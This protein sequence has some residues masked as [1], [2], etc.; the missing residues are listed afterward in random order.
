MRLFRAGHSFGEYIVCAG[1]SRCYVLLFSSSEPEAV[2]WRI[3]TGIAPVVWQ[4]CHDKVIENG[5]QGRI[6]TPQS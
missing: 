5:Q 1:V 4:T 2:S 6:P 3:F